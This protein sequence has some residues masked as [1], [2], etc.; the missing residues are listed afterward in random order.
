[1]NI[2]QN[3][4]ICASM[5]H[6]QLLLFLCSL[7]CLEERLKSIFGQWKA[8]KMQTAIEE[9]VIRAFSQAKFFYSSFAYMSATAAVFMIMLSQCFMSVCQHCN[10]KIGIGARWNHQASIESKQRQRCFFAATEKSRFVWWN[11]CCCIM[12]KVHKKKS[13]LQCS[14]S[15]I[16]IELK[17]KC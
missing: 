4:Y 13:S 8:H 5:R 6:R 9:F 15:T 1:M 2:A 7:L 11:C 3:V 16:F 17:W 14:R 12:F 10:L